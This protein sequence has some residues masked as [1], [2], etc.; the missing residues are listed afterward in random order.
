MKSLKKESKN[1]WSEDFN[2]LCSWDRE[3]YSKEEK[4]KKIIVKKEE[5]CKI[6]KG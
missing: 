3:I 4:M 6:C 5:E 1:K 2:K